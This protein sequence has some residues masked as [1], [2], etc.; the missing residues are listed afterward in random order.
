MR[1]GV[2][3][4]PSSLARVGA[5]AVPRAAGKLRV[6]GGAPP[7]RRA[8]SPA[9]CGGRVIVAFAPATGD[10]EMEGALPRGRPRRGP[11]ISIGRS[12]VLAKLEPGVNVLEAV[13][14]FRAHA[15]GS[16]RRTK[17][18]PGGGPG[19]DVPAGRPLYRFQWNL[20]RWARSAAG[21]SRKA[22][23]RS[24]S[25][26]S[27]PASPTRT[28]STRTPGTSFRKAP[29]WGDT[30]FLPGYDFVNGDAHPNDDEYHGTH[31]ASTIA[32]ATNNGTGMAGLA[33]GCA[34]CR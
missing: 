19:R 12:A 9:A 26:S 11:S 17:R 7:Q 31:V 8:R 33:F 6:R 30:R 20:S 22:S 27:T 15:R 25:P 18:D 24:P 21:G 13:A 2:H 29:D 4:W 1:V 16:V 23:P 32:E 5:S 34:S 10:A 14:R 28:T 3:F